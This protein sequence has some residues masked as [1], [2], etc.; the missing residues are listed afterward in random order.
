M[1]DEESDDVKTVD[2]LS[3]LASDDVVDF[4]MYRESYVLTVSENVAASAAGETPKK[5]DSFDVTQMS[6]GQFESFLEVSGF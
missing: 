2:E 3:E 5:N 6:N 4:S 1:D